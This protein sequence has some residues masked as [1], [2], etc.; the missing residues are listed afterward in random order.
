MGKVEHKAA[1]ITVNRKEKSAGTERA[2]GKRSGKV[3]R[4]ISENY[5]HNAGLHYLQRFSASRAHFIRVMGRKVRRSCL[6]HTDQNE[7]ACM[8]MVHTVAE[9]FERSGLLNDALYAR[10]LAESLKRRGRSRKA[11]TAKMSERG[12]TSEQIR[13]ALAAL[14][15]DTSDRDSRTHD[16]WDI[17][18]ALTFARKKR[19]GPFRK[20]IAGE[21]TPDSLRRE[22]GSFARAGFSYETARKIL[23]MDLEEETQA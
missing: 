1:D 17:E 9:R 14:D 6:F 18:A 10:G 19:L 3:P 8:V 22:L 16:D 11:I 4:R 21:N 15:D 7:D 20:N 5:L 13:H 2:G 23:E 12:L